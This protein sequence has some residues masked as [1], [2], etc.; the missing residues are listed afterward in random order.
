MGVGFSNPRRLLS[1]KQKNPM[2]DFSKINQKYFVKNKAL[3]PLTD[4][5]A[6]DYLIYETAHR[7]FNPSKRNRHSLLYDSLTPVQKNFIRHPVY[8]YAFSK[9][10]Q[11]DSNSVN[12]DVGRKHDSMLKSKKYLFKDKNTKIQMFGTQLK[13][14]ITNKLE[15]FPKIASTVTHYLDH[16][17]ISNAMS[18]FFQQR[19]LTSKNLNNPYNDNNNNITRMAKRVINPQIRKQI[20]EKE[21]SKLYK[22]FSKLMND[23][24][25][26]RN[27]YYVYLPWQIIDDFKH[28]RVFILRKL[29]RF[30]G[31]TNSPNNLTKL[32]ELFEK[33]G[34]TFITM[35]KPLEST[36][37]FESRKKFVNNSIIIH[38]RNS[39]DPLKSDYERKYHWLAGKLLEYQQK[40]DQK[41]S[42]NLN[43]HHNLME[44]RQKSHRLVTP[45]L[46]LQSFGDRG[47]VNN[48]IKERYT[49]FNPKTHTLPRR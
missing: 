27:P 14:L 49:N 48:F 44:H 2:I 13:L 35:T 26:I 25:K 8:K 39:K 28:T 3:V 40:L 10:L 29:A 46:P 20:G 31:L 16:P 4:E 24:S 45:P 38:T 12:Q 17:A 37:N 36:E 33:L 15:D 21:M 7:Y 43:K 18:T 34:D 11:Y 30:F 9:E 41:L 23:Y 47:I 32:N 1:T 19:A 5:Q 22:S 6:I 42:E